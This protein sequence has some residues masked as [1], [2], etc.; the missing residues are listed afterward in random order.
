VLRSDSSDRN[1]AADVATVKLDRF[2]CLVAQLRDLKAHHEM[3]GKARA[4]VEG[5][6]KTLMG[7]AE[8]GTV[9]GEP[10]ITHRTTQRLVVSQKLLKQRFPVAAVA[11]LENKRV[12]TFRLLDR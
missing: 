5:Y 11:C 6:L 12:S 3:Y 2:A 9:D 1:V 7:D 10:V 8:V 4:E